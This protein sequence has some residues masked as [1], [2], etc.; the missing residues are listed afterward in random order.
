M[1]DRIPLEVLGYGQ[2]EAQKLGLF[3]SLKGLGSVGRAP[4]ERDSYQPYKR[5]TIAK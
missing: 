3:V 5:H 1:Q 4:I 2:G